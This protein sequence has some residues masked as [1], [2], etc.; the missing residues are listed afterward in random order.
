MSDLIN[1]TSKNTD[2]AIA[3]PNTVVRLQYTYPKQAG[4][5]LLSLPCSDNA[6]VEKAFANITEKHLTDNKEWG[7]AIREA[8]GYATFKG[9]FIETLQAPNTEF[10][11]TIESNGEHLC[12]RTP[13][14]TKVSNENIKGTRALMRVLEKRKLGGLYQT[15]LWN[16]GI[17]I[18]FK[19]PSDS[20]IVDLNRQLAADTIEFGR[21]TYGL[22]FSNTSVYTV[23][24]LVDFA[25]E[26]MQDTTLN[27]P[28]ISSSE[29]KKII[30]AQDIPSLLWGVACAMYPNG[31]NYRRA[32]V[33][34]PDKCQYIAEELIDLSK[35]LWVNKKGLT[36][37]QRVHM[38]TRSPKSK[39]IEDV[40]RYKQELRCSENK[41]YPI[42]TDF[43]VVLKI[44]TIEEYVESGFNWISSLVSLVEDTAASGADAEEKNLHITR[45]GQATGLR[46][47]LHWVNRIEIDTNTID[48]P[49]TLA[50]TFDAISCDLE[51]QDTFLKFVSTY[52]S[53]S[54][55]AVVG[56]PEYNCPNC[57][58][59]QEGNK[60]VPTHSSI[61][62][63]DVTQLFFSLIMGRMEKIAAR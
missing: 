13:K 25:L 61:I 18:T 24:R 57:G 33:S 30:S 40:K 49:D 28:D 19:P 62:P 10:T 8:L 51:L 3:V 4:E 54:T 15:P 41:S 63:I 42:D 58:G 27:S 7:D 5:V 53:S 34:N 35:L 60:E 37:W 6:S 50:T 47:Y 16:T 52:I 17:W 59:S 23:S 20:S 11:Q 31:F 2:E 39:T 14:F 45:H 29:L 55:I 38:V 43:N 12:G 48:D 21:S 1:E 26:H 32:C 44:P 9:A 36:D 22:I 46:Q 56:I